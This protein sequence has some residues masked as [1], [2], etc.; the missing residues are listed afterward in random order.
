MFAPTYFAIRLF[1]AT[2][3]PPGS[4]ISTPGSVDPSHVDGTP[5]RAI[6]AASGRSMARVATQSTQSAPARTL[7]SNGART[8][9]HTVGASHRG[10]GR[11]SI[12]EDDT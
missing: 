7:E 12:I 3:W 11:R 1:A 2:Y 10:V 9:T 8:S 5:P 6:L 4:T